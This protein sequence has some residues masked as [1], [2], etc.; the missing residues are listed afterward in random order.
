MNFLITWKVYALMKEQY[1]D[2][3]AL[4]LISTLCDTMLCFI[5]RLPLKENGK[6]NIGSVD[7]FLLLLLLWVLGCLFVCLFVL[8]ESHT[9][10]TDLKFLFFLPLPPKRGD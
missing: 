9:A 10:Q 3:F 8:T 1:E 7:T 2:A 5:Q 4:S 6:R